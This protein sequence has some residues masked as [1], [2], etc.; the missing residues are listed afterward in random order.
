[1]SQVRVRTEPGNEISSEVGHCVEDLLL[2]V[3]LL[4]VELLRVEAA[5][6]PVGY[7]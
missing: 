4:R 1:M 7:A 3:E 6:D 2:R 5:S